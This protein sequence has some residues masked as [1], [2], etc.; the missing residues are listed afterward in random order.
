MKNILRK[1]EPVPTIVY[2]VLLAIQG[3]DENFDLL[4]NIDQFPIQRDS[5]WGIA[6]ELEER[7]RR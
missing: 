7:L 1:I 6:Q 3:Y 2:E 4:F 5:I